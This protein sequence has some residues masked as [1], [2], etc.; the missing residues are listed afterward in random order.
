MF[1]SRDASE[2]R[3]HQKLRL[4]SKKK[5]GTRL[6]G[7][8]RQALGRLQVLGPWEK[9]SPLL[10]VVKEGESSV[11]EGKLAAQGDLWFCQ[12]DCGKHCV[13]RKKTCA[14]EKPEAVAALGRNREKQICAIPSILQKIPV[15][16]GSRA[17]KRQRTIP[18][19]TGVY[20]G[21]KMENGAPASDSREKFITL[22]PLWTMRMQ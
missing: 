15:W 1:R 12:C 8:D 7:S 18:V 9:H 16:S 19:D 5:T 10:E 21:E 17:G 22:A 13:C 6:A 20:T 3:A 2:D 4:L 14:L 11:E